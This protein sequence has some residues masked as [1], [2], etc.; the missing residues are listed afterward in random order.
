MDRGDPQG[1]AYGTKE[2]QA[3]ILD[4]R[5]HITQKAPFFQYAPEKGGFLRGFK[6]MAQASSFMP[7]R[8]YKL[9]DCEIFSFLFRVVL[10]FNMMI[11]FY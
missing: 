1:I 10:I 4:A 7:F 9:Y 11:Y 2:H 5:T 3:V 8:P 6:A